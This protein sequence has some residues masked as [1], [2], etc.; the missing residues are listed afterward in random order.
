MEKNLPTKNLKEFVDVH[1]FAI[2][3]DKALWKEIAEGVKET[4]LLE[5]YAVIAT[6]AYWAFLI[7]DNQ[8]SL[9]SHKY[10]IW[11]LVPALFA[12]LGGLRSVALLYRVESIGVFLKTT[13]E[14]LGYPGWETFLRSDS[15]KHPKH[16]KPFLWTGLIF[17]AL[18]F[19]VAFLGPLAFR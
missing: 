3:Q 13:E 10:W 12:V 6:G 19:V 11:A 15:A 2:E 18:V 5:R 14:S 1:Q 4:R 17:W 8:L 9:L 16:P 7:N